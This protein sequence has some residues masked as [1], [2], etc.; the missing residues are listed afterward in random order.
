MV[1]ESKSY[2]LSTNAFK[3]I[4]Q[5]HVVELVF[6]PRGN[7]GKYKG[8]TRRML[9]TLNYRLLN[10]TFGKV[11]L[12]FKPPTHPKPY[13]AETKGL[14]TVW[15]IIMQDWRNIPVKAA[16]LMEKPY[17]MKAEPIEEYIEYF[18]KRI[19]T[20]TLEERKTFMDT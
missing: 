20:M 18:N 10:S 9:C 4:C 15:D 17:T 8:V 13:N 7:L 2:N 11:T 6:N 14:V 1:A 16:Y 3:A 5:T 12:K 19:A